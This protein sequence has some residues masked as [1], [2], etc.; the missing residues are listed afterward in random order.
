MI[1][2][3]VSTDDKKFLKLALNL[4]RRNLGLTG[5][6]PSVGCIITY[7]DIIIG[8]GN[9]QIGG[10][11]HAEVMAI[12]QASEHY[13]FKQNRKTKNINVYIT[14]EPCAH[15]TTSPS[16]AKEIVNFGA[17]RVI[18]LATDPDNRTNGKGKLLMEEAGIKCI[19][20]KIFKNENSD[21][22]KGY[23]KQKKIG[24]PYITLKIGSTINGK[25]ATR[26]GESKWITNSTC[27]KR[28]QLLRSECD[29]ILIG[30]NSIVVDNPRLNLRDQFEEIEN[31][32]IFILDTNFEL[33][34]FQ[35]LSIFEEVGKD[36][37]HIITSKELKDKPINESDSFTRV[38]V[39]NAKIV[40]ESLNL[41][42]ILKIV[43]KVGVNRLLVEGGAK[44]WT[45]FLETGFFDEIVMF[46]GNKIMNDSATSCFNDFLPID[47]RLGDF[48]N[49]T[50]T[51]L[52][53]WK[54]N[55]EAKWIANS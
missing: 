10:R 31:K 30:K 32:P 5:K 17:N 39:K 6:N 20:A 35:S 45:S 12:K 9:T 15:E 4:A 44:V 37:V 3:E 55:I 16:C 19:E 29:G 43:S 48:P 50:L 38:S 47:T 8:R 26:N 11:P 33:S 13:L 51:S 49:L 28:V 41:Q 42:E 52:L 54:D 18:Y 21:I 7:E 46:T 23:L 34:D 36:K 24:L 22:L 2:S 53:K 1:A 40:K 25:I 14:L 27:R